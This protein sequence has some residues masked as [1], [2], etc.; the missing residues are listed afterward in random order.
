[1]LSG[2]AEHRIVLVKKGCCTRYACVSI[3]RCDLLTSLSRRA[4]YNQRLAVYWRC[5]AATSADSNA[6]DTSSR[7]QI[8]SKWVET[9]RGVKFRCMQ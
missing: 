1:M 2:C 7:I 4:L 9:Y 6:A 5:I 3:W 8:V